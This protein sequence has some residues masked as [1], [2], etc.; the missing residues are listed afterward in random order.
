ML[1]FREYRN[2]FVEADAMPQADPEEVVQHAKASAVEDQINKVVD[3]WV[4]DLKKTLMDPVTPY[5][6]Q[7]GIWDRFKNSM[8]NM[9]HGRYNQSNP[10]FWQNKLGDDLGRTTEAFNPNN[11][12]LSEY[13]SLRAVCDSL[14][15]VINEDA[16]TGTENLRIVRLIDQKAQQLKQLLRGIIGGQA[17]AA[18][19]GPSPVQAG[20]DPMAHDEE[21]EEKPAEEKPFEEPDSPAKGFDQVLSM[22]SLRPDQPPTTGKK[23]EQLTDD[24][25][26]AWNTYGGGMEDTPGIID[27][28]LPNYGIRKFPWI[29]RIG[30]PRL[31]ILSAQQRGE[32]S[33]CHTKEKKRSRLHSH[34][35]TILNS[36]DRLEDKDNPITSWPELENRVQH[37]KLKAHARVEFRKKNRTT[38]PSDEEA[39]RDEL[40]AKPTKAAEL[41]PPSKA[42][43]T[44][45]VSTA[46]TGGEPMVPPTHRAAD[47]EPEEVKD[48][49]IHTDTNALDKPAHRVTDMDAP[50]P[51]EGAT[52]PK[53]K[54]PREMKKELKARIAN[55]KNGDIKTQLTRQLKIAKVPED[56]AAIDK[57]LKHH[58][59]ITN[60]LD[61][62]W[63]IHDVKNHYK[64]KLHERKVDPKPLVDRKKVDILSF[65]ERVEYYRELISQR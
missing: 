33:K 20:A 12:T 24:E 11:L 25:I 48:K 10:Y 13:K 15:E 54:S 45:P 49:L 60:D 32:L 39:T 6:N 5:A 35:Y 14:E 53:E 18:P 17:A 16:P 23:W 62:D 37:A 47:I 36:E 50:E 42:D 40:E 61:L 63:T 58:E 46:A 64:R 7:R 26:R 65:N 41:T 1:G 27:G 34:W 2:R 19:T 22:H 43:D 55:V 52:P 56:F 44:I 57:E 59:F 4:A 31:E 51:P 8:A 38:A 29:L 28:C 3:T 30:D 21:E 9:W